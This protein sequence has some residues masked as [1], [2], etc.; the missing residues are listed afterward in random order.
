MKDKA[1]PRCGFVVNLIAAFSRGEGALQ[2][3]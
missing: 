1:A 2:I 3:Q